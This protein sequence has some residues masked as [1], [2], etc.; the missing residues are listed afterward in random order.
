MIWPPRRRDLQFEGVEY[1]YNRR[2]V[3]FRDLSLCI[4]HPVS[5]GYLSDTAH[6]QMRE[7]LADLTLAERNQILLILELRERR[8]QSKRPLVKRLWKAVFNRDRRP[9]LGLLQ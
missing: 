7:F 6:A 5:R 2:T 4:H 1:R 3:V 8:K 9:A